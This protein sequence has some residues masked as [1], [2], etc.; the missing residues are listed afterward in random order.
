VRLSKEEH[1]FL[2][3]SD[4]EPKFRKASPGKLQVG[5]VTVSLTKREENKRR[6]QF[7]EGSQGFSTSGGNPQAHL[8]FF[9]PFTVSLSLFLFLKQK[10]TPRSNLI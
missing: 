8:S 2:I 9:L 5:R 6:E 7:A 10:C 3:I 1:P 4:T